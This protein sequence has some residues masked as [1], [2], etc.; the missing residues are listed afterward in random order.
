MAE[1]GRWGQ[2][3]D[4]LATGS[5]LRWLAGLI[6]GPDESAV[7]ALAAQ[8]DPADAPV[9]LPY[10]SPGEQGAL[11]DPALHGTITG[12]TLGHERSTWPGAWSTASCWKAAGAW[13]SSGRP[14]GYP[15]GADLLVAG[16]SAADEAFRADL[17]DATGRRV[18]MPG[19]P[20]TGQ[21]APT[22]DSRGCGTRPTAH[23]ADFS[24]RGAAL[25][26]ARATG[27]PLPAGSPRA[28]L[29]TASNSRPGRPDQ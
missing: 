6:G 8:V 16:G 22:A 18:I 24:A 21:L 25:L 14:A 5:A 2:E 11:W 26:A 7:I 20:E 29:R 9:M 4:L 12:L 13:R 17:A 1:P 3:M 10:L 19:L 28:W 15:G 27:R 23:S